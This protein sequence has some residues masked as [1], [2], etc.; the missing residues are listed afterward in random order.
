VK[1]F[2]SPASTHPAARNSPPRVAPSFAPYRSCSRPPGIITS[3]N[4][5]PHTEY[6]TVPL[7]L[8]RYV[9]PS[10]S[11]VIGWPARAS[12]TSAAFHTLQPY[13]MP[14][15]RLT[16]VPAAVTAH[17]RAGTDMRWNSGERA[18]PYAAG[19]PA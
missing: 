6:A 18:S 19:K 8:S 15:H 10:F 14:R 13:R 12:S 4:T 7:T 17:A 1:L 9:H 3:A 2:I 5:T 11:P 16:A